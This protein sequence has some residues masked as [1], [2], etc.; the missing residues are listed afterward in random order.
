MENFDL[1]ADLDWL[2]SIVKYQLGLADAELKHNIESNG[3]ISPPTLT[4]DTIYGKFI[5]DRH[6]SNIERGILIIATAFFLKPSVFDELLRVAKDYQYSDT[7]YGGIIGSSQ[8]SFIPT[9]ETIVFLLTNGSLSER[10]DV[11]RVLTHENRLFLEGILEIKY[12]DSKQFNLISFGVI[13]LSNDYK[14]LFLFGKIDKPNYSMDFPASLI[15]Q[16]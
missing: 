11:L 16:K 2:K 10:M 9:G 12:P 1:E 8:G 5:N 3:G 6:F 4:N 14:N 15:V 7:R 13:E